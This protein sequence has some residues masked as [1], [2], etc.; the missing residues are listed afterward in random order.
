M[1]DMKRWQV[2]RVGFKRKDNGRHCGYAWFG[3]KKSMDLFVDE[4]ISD[5]FECKVEVLMVDVTD[6]RSLLKFLNA[7]ANHNDNG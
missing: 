1:T 5:K 3:P 6:K 2:Y 7:Y 4:N